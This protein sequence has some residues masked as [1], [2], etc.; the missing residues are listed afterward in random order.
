MAPNNIKEN[1]NSNDIPFDFW[2]AWWLYAGWH[3]SNNQG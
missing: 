3:V 1:N 2:S